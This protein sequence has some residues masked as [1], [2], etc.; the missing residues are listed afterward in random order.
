MD[1]NGREAP[2]MHAAAPMRLTSRHRVLMRL[3]ITGMSQGDAAEVVGMSEPRVSVVARSELFQREMETMR[4]E[5]DK[6]VVKEQ[7]D[8]VGECRRAL[9][10]LAPTAVKRLGQLLDNAESEGVRAR[11]AGD[12]LDRVGLKGVERVEAKVMPMVP[13]GLLDAL[14]EMRGAP[15]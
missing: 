2:S 12:I 14:R 9:E 11:V 7:V 1:C 8:V 5:I 13:E 10:E 4:R 15:A 6:G 3:L